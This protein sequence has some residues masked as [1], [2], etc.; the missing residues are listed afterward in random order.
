MCELWNLNVGK[1]M[2][3][4][5]TQDRTYAMLE[6]SMNI[7]SARHSLIAS[8]LANID[9]PGYKAKDIDFS[10][11]L[12]IA[13]DRTVNSDISWASGEFSY[14]SSYKPVV[15]ESADSTMRQ[16]GNTVDLDK[17][18]GKLAKT[19]SKYNQATTLYSMKIK[20]LKQALQGG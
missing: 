11:E 17:Q 19:T 15:F 6:E 3:D 5:I 16:D 20:L 12:K 1:T 8:N 10:E 9:T 14:E 2:F 7:A 18:L 4:L 13:L